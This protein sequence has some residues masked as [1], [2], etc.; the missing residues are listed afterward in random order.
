MSVQARWPSSASSVQPV[1][2]SM[3]LQQQQAEG[4]LPS[5]FSH[6]SSA[7]P[8]FTVN[9]FPGS[10]PSVASDHKRNFSVAT[11]AT[12]TQLPDE[13]GIV[14]ASSCVSSGASVPNV[15]INSLSV[16]SVTDAGKTGVQN[17]SS[18]NSGQNSGTNLKSQSP[19]HKGVSTQQYSHS[20]G[21]NF[22]RGGASQKHSSGGGEWSHR[23]TGF[24]GRNQ[25]GAEKNFSSAKM[26]QIYV[27]KQTSS[28]NLRV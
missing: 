23:R 24:M 4:V 12:V 7:D 3:P 8:S 20:S 14:D 26:K 18:N 25:S 21:Y 13:L 5:H 10:Q 22:Q 2:L 11:D 15:D 1:P 19:Q 27:A 28:G 17:C 6:S 9:R 16:S